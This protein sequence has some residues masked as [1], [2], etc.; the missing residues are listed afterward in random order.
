LIIKIVQNQLSVIAFLIV[1]MSENV[2]VSSNGDMVDKP[3]F[4]KKA[5]GVNGAS[6]KD[7]NEKCAVTEI[8]KCYRSILENVGENSKREGLLK[9]PERAAKA[10]L[11]FTKGYTENLH[12]L[13]L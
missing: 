9:T 7:E 4:N 11:F 8:S 10:M 1:I 3:A 2:E 5:N 12:G 6:R 13:K